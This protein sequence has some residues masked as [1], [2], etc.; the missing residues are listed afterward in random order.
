M[1][2]AFTFVA[3]GTVQAGGG[4]YLERGADDEL[5]RALSRRR[6]H[7]HPDVAAD[8][9][10][11]LMNRTAERLC[12][13]GRAARHHRSHR[14][15]APRR[16]PSSGTRAFCSR[17]QDQLDLR[18]ARLGV[19]GRRNPIT[20][21]RHRFTRYLREVALEERH[22]RLVVFVDEIDTTLRLGFTDDFFAA[23]RFL[24]QNRAADPGS[25]AAVVRADRRRH[26]RRFDQGRRPARRSTSDTEST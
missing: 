25:A 3:G 11:S 26:A 10:V 16:R 17:V 14:A 20:R 9:Q 8:G 18:D 19:V 15:R 1:P 5:L 4:V 13:E 6:L 21:S 23:I 24:Y 12:A 7:L 22:E 2:E